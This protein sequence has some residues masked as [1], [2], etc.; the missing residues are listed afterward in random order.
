MILG[1]VACDP[2]D[3][4]GNAEEQD[5][6]IGACTWVANN[7]TAAGIC[8]STSSTTC[9]NFTSADEPVWKDACGS[10]GCE[11]IPGSLSGGTCKEK[12][13]FNCSDLNTNAGSNEAICNDHSNCRW[14]SDTAAGGKCLE[15][16]DTSCAS[17]SSSSKESPFDDQCK[18]FGGCTWISASTPGGTCKLTSETT[19][20][21][22]T[23]NTGSNEAACVAFDGGDMCDWTAGTLRGGTCSDKPCSSYTEEAA[24]AGNDSCQWADAAC[25]D[26][27]AA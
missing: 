5:A 8:Q 4:C 10:F 6:C 20:G 26:K 22:F 12:A 15:K 3:D 13:G 23:R 9:G 7:G 1:I 24:C 11:W 14:V 18:A 25:S 2:S 19:C 17:F 21:D 16:S 27:E